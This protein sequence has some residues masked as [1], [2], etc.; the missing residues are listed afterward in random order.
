M[1]YLDEIAAGA[2]QKAEQKISAFGLPGF[3]GRRDRLLTMQRGNGLQANQYLNSDFRGNQE[4]LVGR[5]EDQ[6]MGRGPSIAGTMLN[7]AA[8]RNIAGQQA[9]AQSARPNQVGLA[10][11]QAMQ[12]AGRINQGL[13]GQA[14][15]ARLHEQQQANQLLAGVVGQGRGQDIGVGQSRLQAQ[16]ALLDQERLNAL[17]QQQGQLTGMGI[18]AQQVQPWER[19][20]GA[21]VGLGT[22]ALLG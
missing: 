3:E 4:A 18:Q 10:Q 16:L 5:L 15:L 14:A 8:N 1:S 12:N 11:R 7:Q 21:G 6:A 17:A 2:R 13:A 19:F 20:L 22:A 9:L